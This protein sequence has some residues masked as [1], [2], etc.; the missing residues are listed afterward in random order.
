L[1]VL[2]VAYLQRTFSGEGMTDVPDY[3]VSMSNNFYGILR[4]GW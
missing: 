2:Y 3:S 4:C 1:Y